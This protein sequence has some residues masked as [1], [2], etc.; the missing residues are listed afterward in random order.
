MPPSPPRITSRHHPF[1]RRCRELAAGRG[2]DG[3]ILL[4]GAHLV[5]EAARAGVPM[6]GVLADTRGLSAARAAG[7][8]GAP[9]YEGTTDVLAAA[10]PV[11]TSAGVV[12]VAAW[13]PE[14]LT[15]VLQRPQPLLVGLVDVQDPGNVGGIIRT[16]DAL[17]ASGV[18]ALGSTAD[19]A[20]WKALRGAMGSTFRIPIARGAT[21]EAITAA[22]AAGVGIAAAVAGDGRPIDEAPLGA[23]LL[24]LVGNEGAGLPPAVLAQVDQLLTIPM[25][26]G[27][28]S[29]NVGVS[30]ALVLW[31]ARRA[32]QSRRSPR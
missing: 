2:T 22:R 21:D 6:V 3:E 13:R 9:V 25:R 23:P 1:V 30:A 31:E 15:A 11:R 19:P 4:D 5:E 18:L 28:N 27:L 12:A 24:V 8:R 16:A 17:G 26:S 10:S 20:G 7:R 32:R 14:S 29:L